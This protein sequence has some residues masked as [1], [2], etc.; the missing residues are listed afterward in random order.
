MF[1]D[2]IARRSFVFNRTRGGEWSCQA[3]SCTK[4]AQNKNAV[5][6]PVARLGWGKANRFCRGALSLTL[7]VRNGCWRHGHR[8]W[9]VEDLVAFWESYEQRR[10]ERAA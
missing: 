6:T 5:Q 10:M 9:S 7:T 1:G 8:L 4:P 3:N 2:I